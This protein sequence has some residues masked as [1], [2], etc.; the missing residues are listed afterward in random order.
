MSNAPV[1]PVHRAWLA[2]VVLGTCAM[3][4]PAHARTAEEVK[5]LVA[6]AVQHIHEVGRV[7]AFADITRP[8][9]GFVDGELHV[10]CDAADGTVLAHGGNPKLV[11]KV[12]AD[13]SD[14]E[15]R[16]PIAEATRIGLTRGEGWEEYLWP[17]PL[18]G[19][20]ERK[21]T[22]VLR[23]DEVTVCGSGYY[24]PDSP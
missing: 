16:R 3:A 24:L 5:A 11:G 2:A 12:M 6:R 15:G 17:N 8:D 13:V 1:C 14:S 10:F 21:S 22:F 20:I 9:G 7:Q 19:R 23:V 4:A 18:T